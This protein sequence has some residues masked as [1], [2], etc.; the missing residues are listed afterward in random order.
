[1]AIKTV[2]KYAMTVTDQYNE[3]IKNRTHWNKPENA[4]GHND[5]YTT[6]TFTK[7]KYATHYKTTYVKDKNGKEVAKKV[8]DKW[9]YKYTHP[10]TIS[11]HDFRLDLPDN[12]KIRN[13]KFRCRMTANRLD[14]RIPRCRFNIYS[15]NNN[16]E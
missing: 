12:A 4:I 2:K 6:A 1:M 16:F 8:A 3:N 14:T 5:S 10:A 13:I 15:K 11:A 7:E 9:G